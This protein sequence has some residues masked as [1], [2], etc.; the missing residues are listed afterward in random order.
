MNFGAD[1]WLTFKKVTVE[2]VTKDC[3]NSESSSMDLKSVPSLFP[4]S[5]STV[6]IIGWEKFMSSVIR[7]MKKG[8]FTISVK[9]FLN[10]PD[11]S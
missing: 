8:K 3:G 1:N 10:V 4:S 7:E 6:I 11:I 5:S 9:H 2:I